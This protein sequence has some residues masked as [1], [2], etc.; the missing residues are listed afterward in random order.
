MIAGQARFVCCGAAEEGLLL[1]KKRRTKRLM[2]DYKRL[3]DPRYLVNGV[4]NRFWFWV[5]RQ[6]Q[7]YLAHTYLIWGDRDRVS[8]GRGVALGDAIL[9]CRSGRIV[10]EDDVFFGHHVLILTG[11]HDY[12]LRGQERLLTVPQSGAD[13]TIRRGAWIASHVTVLGPCEIGEDAVI[14]S[15]SVVRGNIPAGMIYGGIPAR[16]I[17]EIDFRDALDSPTSQS[18]DDAVSR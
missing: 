12:R 10:I 5:A 11:W 1:C 8:I 2:V 3:L 9:N 4:R 16:P 15:G 14:A 18:A 6:L 17:R 7:F 13:I